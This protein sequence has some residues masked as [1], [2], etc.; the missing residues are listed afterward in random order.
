MTNKELLRLIRKTAKDRE[1]KLDLAGQDISSLPPEINQLKHLTWLDLS[2]NNLRSLPSE[3]GELSKLIWLY[4]GDN[5]LEVLPRQIKQLKNLSLLNL[6]KNNLKGL[7]FE[8]EQLKELTELDLSRNKLSSVP[9]GIL[10]LEKITWLNLS[11]NQLTSVP[12]DIAQMENLIGLNLKGNKL[13]DLPLEI[14]QSKSIIEL[15]VTGNILK[16]LTSVSNQ[17]QGCNKN[18]SDSNYHQQIQEQPKEQDRIH[19]IKPVISRKSTVNKETYTTKISSKD[20]QTIFNY[21]LDSA[22][23]ISPWSFQKGDRGFRINSW[24]FSEREINELSE[25]E[26]EVKEALE[27]NRK[28]YLTRD[29]YF[30]LCCSCGISEEE[31]QLKLSR[32]FHKSG[33]CLHFQNNPLLRK[34]IFLKPDWCDTAVNKVL[35]NDKVKEKKGEFTQDDLDLIWSEKK[36]VEIRDELLQVMLECN[37]FY[38]VASQKNTYIAPQLLSSEQ[39][40]YDWDESKNLILQCVYEFMPKGILAH[41]IAALPSHIDKINVWRTGITIHD[42]K[43]FAEI[44]ENYRQFKGEIKIRFAGENKRDLLSI[45]LYELNRI[46]DSYENLKPKMLVPCNCHSCKKDENPYLYEFEQLRNFLN[47]NDYKIQCHASRQMVDIGTLLDEV[48]WLGESKSEIV[49]PIETKEVFISYA[50][51]DN[52]EEPPCKREEIVNKIDLAFKDTD[53]TLI[54]DK[55]DLGFKGLIKSFMQ[56][57]GRGKAVIVVISDKYLKSQHCMFELVEIAANGSFYDRIFPIVLKDAQIYDPVESIDYVLHWEE[58]IQKLD[59]AMKKVGSANMTGYREYIDL[60]T[61][62][63]ATIAKLTDTLRNMNAL[64]PEMHT[65]SGFSELISAIEKRLES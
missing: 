64:T 26:K 53:I 23:G 42:N 44:I 36:Y 20:S 32:Y 59:A 25:S 38:S 49:K 4:V 43:A 19:P 29:E 21:E 54:R 12:S 8:I 51:G 10:K 13:I 27:Q 62:I 6:S 24:S 16:S 35:N 33:I 22:I 9:E 28:N 52:N 57:I 15:E 61:R 50:W 11:N 63:R 3:I 46:H 55:R 14:I 65:E 40:D 7:S 48:A 5:K 17:S 18:P 31:D 1:P 58:K 45:T 37:L 34:I 56:L 30:S 39:P 47:H 60:Y 41:F 2:G